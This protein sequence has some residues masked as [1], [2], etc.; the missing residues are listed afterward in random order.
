MRSFSATTESEAVVAAPAADIWAVLTDPVLLPELT[1]LLTR[2]DA[3]GD[4]W[5][6]H[7]MQIKA[8]GVGISPKFTERMLF[9][10]GHRIDYSHAPAEGVHERTGAH[11]WYQLDE[12]EQGT[13]LSI[14]LTLSV[15]LPLP[16][17]AGPA[18]RRVMKTTITRTGERF[19]SN[20]LKHLGTEQIGPTKVR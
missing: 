8:L 7:M 11:G 13:Q 20:L 9:D 3:D 12:V 14:S 18:V 5:T 10:D 15:E 4:I 2:I 19:S 6:W 17:T 16:R 1:P